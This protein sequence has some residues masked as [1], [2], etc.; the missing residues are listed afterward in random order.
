MKLNFQSR[1]KDATSCET[2]PVLVVGASPHVLSH[3]FC[4]HG[5]SPLPQLSKCPNPECLDEKPSHLIK[6]LQ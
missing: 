5:I 1:I 3:P 4:K 2:L 6:I